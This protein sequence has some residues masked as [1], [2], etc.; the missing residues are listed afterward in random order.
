M[1]YGSS[2][3]KGWTTILSDYL[4][5]FPQ[6][7]TPAASTSVLSTPESKSNIQSIEVEIRTPYTLVTKE[8]LLPGIY[9]ALF[10]LTKCR[11]L[12][13]NFST[14][15]IPA[16]FLD[17]IGNKGAVAISLH[18]AHSRLLFICAHLAAHSNQ[19]EERKANVKKIFDEMSV[20]DLTGGSPLLNGS[21][22]EKSEQL[23]HLT[24]RFDQTFFMGDL[25]SVS[26]SHRFHFHFVGFYTT[27]RL[28]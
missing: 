7:S 15:K 1:T 16:G 2:A 14:G 26:L 5:T 6:S 13:R 11:Q 25:K 8:R 17:R 12:I 21:K 28:P 10:C 27:P 18:F 9:I 24:D 22:P 19:V 20:D 4:C 3:R 23:K